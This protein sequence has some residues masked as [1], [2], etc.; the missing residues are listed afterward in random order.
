M[1]T[2]WIIVIV[3]III[4]GAGS[5]LWLNNRQPQVE[6]TTVELKREN[7]VQ[8]V[9]EVGTVKAK[10]ELELNFSQTGRLN[11]ISSKV[12]DVVKKDQVLA[13]LDQSSFLIKEQEALSSLNVARA[14]LSK[15]LAGSTA[16]EIAIYEAQV[17]SAKT[18]YLAAMEDYTKTQDSVDETALQAQKKLTDLQSDDPL[19]NTYEQSI[20][21]NRDSLITI[22]DSKIVVAGVALDYADRIL[23]D[24]DIK[25]LL[26]VKNLFYLANTQNYYSQSLILK[27]AA[28]NDSAAARSNPTDAN[29]NK[30]VQSSLDYLNGTF[31]TMNNLFSVL[32]NS[33]IS[34]T[35]LSQTSL[36]TFK[37]NVNS[38]VGIINT[39][40][41]TLQTAD[42]T[43]KSSIVALSD[44]VK[45]AQNSLNSA[46]IAGRQQL[47]SAQSRVDTG[48]EAWDVAQKQL[49]QIKAPGRV[50][51]VALASAQVSQAGANLNLIKKQMADNIISAPMDGQIIN[52]N[53]E[54]G[55]QV[56]SAKAVIVMLT[57][58]NF[59]VEVDISESDISK[60][61]I[62]NSVAVTFDAFGENRKFQG[63]VYFIEP[64]ST[65]IQDVIYYKVKIKFTDD[66]AALTDIK[67]GMTANVIITTNSKDGVL[68]VPARAVLE[69]TGAGK[70][71]RVLRTGN[72]VE[73]I[74]VSI[75]LSGNEGMIEVL[76]DQ[77]KE[78]EAIVTFVKN[79]Q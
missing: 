7:L 23:S 69:K 58:N 42:H 68:S 17:N 40:I 79:G 59:E 67:S 50:E 77:L 24:N 29:L 73:E 78:G 11:K 8:T 44:A 45:A 51:D 12:G 26:S 18:S 65:V 10:K 15:L 37:A 25:N 76:A 66:A 70:Y 63:V 49:A 75:G 27:T 22:A 64:A 3:I 35:F 20:E 74:P 28:V 30:M 56:N 52:I 39:G 46:Q 13:E 43:L 34:S 47:A 38:Q 2:K 19:V 62:N 6:Y 9:S 4:A 1:K 14:G 72:Q 60:I 55:E 71:I 36:E 16:S 31:Q 32:E 54:I 41:S 61:K 48:R 53:Y 5:F 57:E 33:I 21:N